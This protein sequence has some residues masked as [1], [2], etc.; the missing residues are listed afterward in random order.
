MDILHDLKIEFIYKGGYYFINNKPHHIVF[1]QHVNN[2]PDNLRIQ[3]GNKIIQEIIRMH[4]DELEEQPIVWAIFKDGN[5][6]KC[7]EF[8]SAL[9]DVS[10]LEGNKSLKFKKSDFEEI[11]TVNYSSMKY[12]SKLF[13]LN[14][15]ND[16]N[17]QEKENNT[18]NIQPES[19]IYSYFKSFNYKPWNAISEFVDNS[20]A[21][22]FDKEHEIKLNSL[23]DFNNLEIKINF[24]NLS[25]SLTI[26]D[27]A[28]GMEILDFKRAFRL[29][30][31]PKDKSGRNEFGMGLKTSAFWFGKKLTVISTEYGSVNEYELTLD[32][33]VLDKEKLRTLN[34]IKRKVPKSIHGTTVKI[35]NI[36][37]DKAITGP[38][39]KGRINKELSTIFRRDILGVNSAD[40]S[41]SIKIYFNDDLLKTEKNKYSQIYDKMHYYLKEFNEK[42]PGY[43]YTIN[44]NKIKALYKKF[45]FSVNYNGKYYHIK[46]CIGFLNNTG[47]S[48]AGFVLYRRGRVIEGSV[49]EF[50]KPD[51]I[52]GAPNSFES[53]RLFGEIDLEDIP[54][55]QAKDSFLWPEDLQ[56][57][58]FNGI[59]ERILDIIFIVKNFKKEDK[60]PD[61]YE[62]N[63][64]DPTKVIKDIQE[65][66]KYHNSRDISQN[67][68][69]ENQLGLIKNEELKFNNRI[70]SD[71]EAKELLLANKI[72]KKSSK[73]YEFD[74]IKYQISFVNMGDFVEIFSSTDNDYDYLVE[75]NITHG[76]FSKYVGDNEFLPIIT[77]FALAVV[78]AQ[79]NFDKDDKMMRYKTFINNFISNRGV[80]TE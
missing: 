36:Y 10:L 5:Y 43:K 70:I 54:V 16:D 75:I 47:A 41:K 1:A 35:E 61:G 52:Y 21:S 25:N 19:D 28:Y 57:Q 46:C 38:R 49:G 34:I 69:L 63:H 73:L 18:I 8:D 3:T 23:K 33:D 58:I 9:D 22:Y 29:K 79:I 71:S 13:Y 7:A 15:I 39:T 37:P 53:Q 2:E 55:S 64:S 26:V 6:F 40:K 59:K 78:A 77:E 51:I 66:Q 44:L 48:N 20:T 76:F 12:S 31:A 65:S 32:T 68:N 56:E 14:S 27:N 50:L 30:D 60:L 72:E 24:N 4:I 67:S 11:G 74:G 80:K 17:L 42:N 62:V 45:Q